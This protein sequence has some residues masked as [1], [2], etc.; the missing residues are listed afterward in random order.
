MSGAPCPWDI[1]E[2]TGFGFTVGAVLSTVYQALNRERESGAPIVG[3]LRQIR[4]R[5]PIRGSNT[6]A[7]SLIGRE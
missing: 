1:V 2:G 5:A 6:H 4:R 3:Q 7:L